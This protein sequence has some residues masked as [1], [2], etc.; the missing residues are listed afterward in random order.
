MNK[1]ITKKER[2]KY[3]GHPSPRKKEIYKNDFFVILSIKIETNKF[4]LLD[5]FLSMK[6][7]YYNFY[8]LNLVITKLNIT[9]LIN[10]HFNLFVF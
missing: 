9:Y 1:Y 8:L 4:I 2:N 6:S 7:E 5:S 10:L 3:C